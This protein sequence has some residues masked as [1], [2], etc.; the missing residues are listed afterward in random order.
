MRH[1]R[2]GS[3]PA[4][5]PAKAARRSAIVAN[6]RIVIETDSPLSSF[7]PGKGSAAMLSRCC[8]ISFRWACVVLVRAN[9]ERIP[10]K[11]GVFF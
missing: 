10:N 6:V 1:E 9:R 2:E 4:S 3:I 5:L 11:Q 8:K 7:L